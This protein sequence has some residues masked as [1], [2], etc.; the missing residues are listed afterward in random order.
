MLILFFGYKII[1][2]NW[3]INQLYYFPQ[4]LYI[5]WIV[6]ALGAIGLLFYRP[7]RHYLS[8]FL[9][10]YLWG[11]Y[12]KIGR[13]V[14]LIIALVLFVIFRFE[15]HLYG[16][17]YIR[18]ANFAQ[19]SVPIFPWYQYGSTIIPY[20][21][22]L[23]TGIFGVEELKAAFWG[24]HITSFISGIIFIYFLLKTSARIFTDNHDRTT[25]LL[26]VIFSGLPLYFFGMVENQPSL[27]AVA[28][29]L[30]YLISL[31]EERKDIKTLLY[32]WGV[33]ILGI[34][35]NLQ[36]ITFLPLTVYL[37]FHHLIKRKKTGHRIGLLCA[38][39]VIVAGIIITY[40]KAAGNIAVENAI[41]LLR[42]K[43][44]DVD[45][46][47]F[48]LHHLADIFNL[49]FLF[50]PLFIIFI[51]VI[52]AAFG[53]L[54]NDNIYIVFILL[55]LS[56]IIYLWM[57]NPQN[58]MMPDINIFGFLLLGLIFS[59]AYSLLKIKDK[60]K[61]SRSMVMALC[62]AAVILV[63]P[64]AIVHLS[65]SMTEK[66]INDFLLYN[67]TKYES[68]LLGLRD[69]HYNAGNYKMS[70]E[71]DQSLT[72]KVPG[73]LEARL[74]NDLYAHQHY[75]EAFE[76]TTNIVRRYPYKAKYRILQA[77]MLK[78]YRRF[79]EAEQELKTALRLEPYNTDVY[80]FLSELYRELEMEPKCYEVLQKAADFAPENMDIMTDLMGYYYRTRQLNL[81]D[82]MAR[83]ALEID[84]LAPYSYMYLGLLAEKFEL[85][86]SAT[87]LYEKFIE[88][89]DILPE[90]TL[91]RKRMNEIYLKQRDSLSDR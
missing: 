85:Y 39:A 19:R 82:S 56:Q 83:A 30:I 51:I 31:I 20:L 24:Y 74:V 57:T 89:N 64:G 36:F 49:F 60:F 59:G 18:V 42:G 38:L 4:W 28:S 54:K 41:L 91:I 88:I 47:L 71:Y 7:K 14:L 76:Y 27:P 67:E 53:K 65:A 46:S 29:A 44:P 61:I 80:H 78:F 32:I 10:P 11:D 81:A 45:Y 33:T 48:S 40:I 70:D 13:T 34:I 87:T 26:L 52:I 5:V 17:G 58:G 69:Y 8:E 21:M 68:A 15:A 35:L 62:P 90:V 84:S 75:N 16:D 6:L 43:M 1:G 37:T 55:A 66:S 3:G 86:D 63:L 72:G 77:N 23:I 2:I 25:F 9:A 79:D 12:E 50:V 73:A 22:Y